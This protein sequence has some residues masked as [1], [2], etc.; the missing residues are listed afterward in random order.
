MTI[1]G[2]G[3]A[4]TRDRRHLHPGVVALVIT[5]VV[6]LGAAGGYFVM[7][8]PAGTPIAAASSAPVAAP[9]S[10]SASPAP[11]APDG[12]ATGSWS[13]TP[14]DDEESF[15]TVKGDFAAFGAVVATVTV[16]PGL[17]D[18]SCFTFRDEDGDYMRH[19]DYRLRFDPKD[20]S[21]L[22]R[23]DATFC[24]EDDQPAGSFRVRSKNYPDYFLHRRG[25][26]LYID[27]PTDDSS[28]TAESTF[29]LRPAAS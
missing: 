23:K 12:L 1:Y 3:G 5:A 15:L 7:R 28:F 13:I 26:E 6:I 29:S 8:D 22:F 16:V 20:D 14:A 24:A 25:T 18:D 17:A 21:E 11:T 9:P 27:K 4:G 2:H 19:F 10:P